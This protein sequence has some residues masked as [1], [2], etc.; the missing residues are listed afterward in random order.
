MRLGEESRHALRLPRRGPRNVRADLAS[1]LFPCHAGYIRRPGTHPL[2]T[3]AFPGTYWADSNPE[4]PTGK[5]P[6]R[7]GSRFGHV[8]LL[9]RAQCH[10]HE[11]LPGALVAHFL[12]VAPGLRRA[13]DGRCAGRS[14]ELSWRRGWLPVR[15]LGGSSAH[16]TRAPGCQ[17]SLPPMVP[18]GIN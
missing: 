7:R 1:A 9:A 4:V 16:H 11:Q 3:A 5:G 2:L 12:L 10:E 14:R 6:H 17:C 15:P 18:S 8:F 13:Y